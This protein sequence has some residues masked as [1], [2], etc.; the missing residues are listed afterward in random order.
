MC[1]RDQ[2]RVT[3]SGLGVNC[4]IFTQN[5]AC[6][7]GLTL[8][9]VVNTLS[10]G[11]HAAGYPSTSKSSVCWVLLQTL[12]VQSEQSESYR[13]YGALRAHIQFVKFMVTGNISLFNETGM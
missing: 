2:S 4:L 10:D 1:E 13:A 6:A 3:L 12:G 7:G 5:R 8:L 9:L 11:F